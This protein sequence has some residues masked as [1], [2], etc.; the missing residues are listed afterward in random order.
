MP[1]TMP[2]LSSYF[3]PCSGLS[4]EYLRKGVSYFL[5]SSEPKYVVSKVYEFRME[6]SLNSTILAV[7]SLSFSKAN[8]QSLILKIGQMEAIYSGG[9]RSQVFKL[10]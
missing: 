10:W 3:L 9:I 1:S 8:L 4:L 6:S 5:N 7:E 2:Y